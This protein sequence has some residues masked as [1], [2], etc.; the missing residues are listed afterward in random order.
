[1][2]WEPA[3]LLHSFSW[4]WRLFTSVHTGESWEGFEVAVAGASLWWFMLLPLLVVTALRGMP[5]DNNSHC[6]ACGYSTIGLSGNRCPECG[7][8][9]TP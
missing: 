5:N 2:V 3:T 8:T 9:F 6:P 7:G 4:S 1:M